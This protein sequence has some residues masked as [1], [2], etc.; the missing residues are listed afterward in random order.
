ML[1]EEVQVSLQHDLNCA[2]ELFMEN[3]LCLNVKKTKWSLMGTYQKLG[4]AAEIS[5]T[6]NG[7]QLER[8][9]EYK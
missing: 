4:K 7:E 3:C 5:I 6:V 1:K 9:D 2:L 8:V